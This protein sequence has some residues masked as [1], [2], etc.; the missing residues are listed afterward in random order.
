MR[1]IY[2]SLPVPSPAPN[3]FRKIDRN[4]LK[5]SRRH[6]S[7][8]DS[9]NGPQLA[10]GFFNQFP[11]YCQMV[12]E[13]KNRA[14][15]SII[16]DHCGITHIPLGE[17]SNIEQVYTIEREAGRRGITK[18]SLIEFAS[19]EDA[20]NITRQARHNEDRLMP[21]PMKI[22]RY[23]MLSN[24]P[25][26]SKQGLQFPV[27][28]IRLS[29]RGDLDLNLKNYTDLVKRNTMSMVALKMRFITLVNLEQI[30]CSGLFGAYE[31]MPFGSSVIDTG[32]DLG[33]LD[34]V[35]TKRQ[36]HNKL[37]MDTLY[38]KS[39]PTPPPSDSGIR[40]LH[41]DKSLPSSP[42]DQFG[43]M[44]AMK[45]F[46]TIMKM[47][48]PLTDDRA[49]FFQSAKVPI[50][51]FR[52]R[53]TNIE[54]DLSFNLGLDYRN[55]DIL[56]TN[57]SGI[58]MSQILYDICRKNNLFTAVVIYIR[59]FAKVTSITS[60]GPNVGF[61]NFQLLSLIMFYLQQVSLNKTTLVVHHNNRNPIIPP[62]KEI[63]NSQPIQLTDVELDTVLPRIIKGFF[64][65]YS[66]FRF[67]EDK[68]LNLYTARIEP[69]PDN[70]CLYIVNPLDRRRNISHNVCRKGLAHF[71]DQCK[72]TNALLGGQYPRE[73]PLS[74]LNN[75]M[76]ENQQR[77]RSKSL[78][79]G[80][81]MFEGTN[82]ID[83]P[84]K[85]LL[86]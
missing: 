33:D 34:L 49:L 37:I 43:E 56:A 38:P 24:A 61:T 60:K 8:S 15:R 41:L 78:D 69:K 62:F 68:S 75:L 81:V 50:I 72:Q 4:L 22:F 29:N 70:S 45:L 58:I 12:E 13:A 67:D 16:I 23:P 48:M 11:N 6:Q 30:L 39:E 42:S 14:R 17:F 51:R 47:F 10:T 19:E 7:A 9:R 83:Q 18:V 52:A 40:L 59:I 44:T 25:D 21:V 26:P 1:R 79:L 84:P 55:R 35:V 82:R 71:V 74:L 57:Y 36:S 31:L 32:S 54:C 65:Y 66:K 20:D 28:N 80:E 64:N 5:I 73:C 27:E 53:V 85:R 63:M 2:S 77:S 76:A 86:N 3:I 46:E